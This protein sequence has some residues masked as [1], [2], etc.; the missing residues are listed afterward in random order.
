MCQ[1]YIDSLGNAS[2][3]MSLYKC[4]QLLVKR[5]ANL[6]RTVYQPS[7]CLLLLTHHSY[8]CC[9]AIYDLPTAMRQSPQLCRL[10]ITWDVCLAQQMVG[11]VSDEAKKLKKTA[12]LQNSPDFVAVQLI[13][14]LRAYVI[15]LLLI[16][17][18]FRNIK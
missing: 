5:V 11:Y 3:Q 15:A 9:M 14:C 10:N 8:N 16:N 18:T 17:Y 7:M 13:T 12:L 6:Y 4:I 1:D 2:I